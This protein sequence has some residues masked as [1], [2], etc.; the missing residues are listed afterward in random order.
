MRWGQSQER[1]HPM[2]LETVVGLAV[3]FAMFATFIVGLGGAQ[4]W[5]ALSDRRDAKAAVHAE[6]PAHAEPMRRAA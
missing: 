4:L 6:A 3:I 1:P 5:V 2:P